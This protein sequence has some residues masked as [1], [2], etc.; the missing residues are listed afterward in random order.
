MA[1]ISKRERFKLSPLNL[2]N[3]DFQQVKLIKELIQ[4][5]VMRI[6]D[7][8]HVHFRSTSKYRLLISFLVQFFLQKKW[9]QIFFPTAS[10]WK[11]QLPK[12]IKEKRK[13]IS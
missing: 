3:Y 7:R 4:Q 13:E 12:L 9:V 8:I 11:F 6:S 10:F 2:L 5:K 1:V